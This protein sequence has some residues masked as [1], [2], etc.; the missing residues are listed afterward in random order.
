MG[1]QVAETN[2]IRKSKLLLQQIQL[3]FNKP[4]KTLVFTKSV[5]KRKIT[6]RQ[7]LIVSFLSAE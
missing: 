7:G 3:H 4:N 1:N 5:C 6:F 2:W